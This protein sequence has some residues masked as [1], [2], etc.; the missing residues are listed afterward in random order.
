MCESEATPNQ[1]AVPKYPFYL[2]WRGISGDVEIFRF[3]AQ[4]Q[5]T[6]STP[7]KV[8]LETR[9]FEAIKNLQRCLRYVGARNNMLVSG[10]DYRFSD[11]WNPWKL[12]E[13]MLKVNCRGA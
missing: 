12:A 3:P 6:H 9:I 8:C 13:L 11:D 5:V 1:P 7:D 4:E 10:N 2:F